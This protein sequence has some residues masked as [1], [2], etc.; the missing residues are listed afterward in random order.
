M[1]IAIT[2]LVVT[3]E[4]KSNQARLS[5]VMENSHQKLIVSYWLLMTYF[6]GYFLWINLFPRRHCIKLRRQRP[7]NR[8]YF[9][10]FTLRNMEWIITF[11][12]DL[13]VFFNSFAFL[14]KRAL[15]GIEV[16]VL[17]TLHENI[18][19]CITHFKHIL[20]VKVSEPIFY[21]LLMKY[22]DY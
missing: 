9:V 18:V 17:K 4:L 12:T 16:T 21:I 13:E 22:G 6:R 11:R 3:K 20:N 8:N 19:T 2:C 1:A 15:L 14:L 7:K 10:I 5:Q